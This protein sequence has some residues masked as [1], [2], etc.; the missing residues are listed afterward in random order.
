MNAPNAITSILDDLRDK[1]DLADALDVCVHHCANDPDFVSEFNRLTGSCFP[2]G[3]EAELER[4]VHFV[5]EYVLLPLIPSFLESPASDPTETQ[6][7]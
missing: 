2:Q 5:G 1:S 7:G 4:F 6:N 3:D